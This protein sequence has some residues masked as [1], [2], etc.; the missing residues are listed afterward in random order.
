MSNYKLALLGFG[1]VGQALARLL[2]KKQQD[3]QKQYDITFRVTGI[4]TGR[5]GMA[6][7]PDGLDLEKALELMR[8][9]HSL[10][11]ISARPASA[12]DLDFIR[13]CGA[14][15]LFENTPVDYAS[16]Q[17]AIDHLRTA[18][19]VGM[20]AITANKGPV[21][22]AYQQLAKEAATRGRKFYFESTVMDGAP[23]FSLFREALPAATPE[24]LQGDFELD[25][26]PDPDPHGRRAS[27]S[28]RQSPMRSQLA[29]LRPTPAA[30]SMA[31]MLPSR[32][33]LWQ[34]S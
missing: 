25:H 12:T 18:L 11:E 33:A 20:H 5:H 15:V 17:P 16:G 21:V 10:R 7:D 19:Q 28:S 9:G 29:S 32:S 22:H 13:I 30:T 6:V 31:G 14:N 26:Q 2:L 27:R 34:P 23:I 24:K 3:I 1:N 8:V 4:A